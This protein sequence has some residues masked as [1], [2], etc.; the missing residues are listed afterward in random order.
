MFENLKVHVEALFF[1]ME[2]LESM[3][4]EM[5]SG[6]NGLRSHYCTDALIQK[7]F[8]DGLLILI[9]FLLPPP[10][11]SSPPPPSSGK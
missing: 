5:Y 2:I 11:P 4:F 8:K 1:N 3:S 7:K 9:L 10:F 6:N